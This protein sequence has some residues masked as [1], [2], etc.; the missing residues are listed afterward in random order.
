[1]DSE[2]KF[3]YLLPH[4]DFE[5]PIEHAP[6]ALV[7]P[8][9]ARLRAL[10]DSSA[11]V[12]SLT[13]RF[14]DQFGERI[15]PS[16]I[17]I[18]SDAPKTVDFYAVVCFRNAIAIAS[19]IDGVTFRISGGTAGYPQWSD[20][21]DFYPFT[22]SKDNN[23]SAQSIASMEVNRPD[24][25]RGHRAPYLPTSHRLS[26]GFDKVILAGCLRQWDRR[27][28]R[29]RQEWKTRVLFRALEIACQASRVPA[30]GT[31][32]PTI[33]DMGV[34]I[35]LWVS[36]FEILSHPRTGNANLGTVL[37]LLA[38]V[39]WLDPKLK[40][41]R[42]Q[43]VYP[44]KNIR[45][46]NWAQR[47]YYEL[48]RARNDFLHGNPV[49]AGRLFPAKRSGGPTLLHCAPLIFRA[50]L[51]SVLPSMRTKAAKGDLSAKMAEYL[52]AR[53]VQSRYEKALLRC[54]PGKKKSR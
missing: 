53:S 5:E 1:M 31:R 10:A 9:D 14:T 13:T 18:R 52:I 16:A 54:R 49:A 37:D 7:P 39:D 38:K 45:R 24:R 19:I 20:F 12:K 28:I 44:K 36:A 4:T 34:G 32:T 43:V 51:S 42:F 6:L 11:A 22:A 41:T 27:F 15:E 29:G 21:F 8:G 3:A 2:W 35:A 47:F 17:L 40:A 33:H 25:F 26:F 30:V 48:Y 46:I 23:L 50:A